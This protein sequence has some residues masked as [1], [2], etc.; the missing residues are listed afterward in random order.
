MWNYR[1]KMIFVILVLCSKYF[2]VWFFERG[3]NRLGFSWLGLFLSWCC[4]WMEDLIWGEQEVE[5][6]VEV[7]CDVSLV[8][9]LGG[10]VLRF[11]LRNDS[12]LS[13]PSLMIST[14]Y[15]ILYMNMAD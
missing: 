6:E 12:S 13:V 4:F 14:F 2:P 1:L 3:R 11:L 9:V 5:Q 7:V 15:L 10:K 8:A